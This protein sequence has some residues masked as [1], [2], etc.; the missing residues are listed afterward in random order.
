MDKERVDANGE[1]NMIQLLA[2]V[3]SPVGVAPG[4]RFRFEQWEPHLRAKHG[5]AFDYAPFESERLR[6]V[7]RLPGRELEKAAALVHDAVRRARVLGAAREYDGV[8]IHREISALGPAFYERIVK[9]LRVPIIFDFDDAIWL[10]AAYSDASVNSRFDALR[11]PQKTATICRLASAI[12]VGNEYLAEYAQQFNKNVFVVPT[13]IELAHYPIQSERPAG[14]AIEIVWMGSFSTLEAHLES[15]RTAIERFAKMRK[16]VVRVICDKPPKRP[17]TGT[18]T[19]FEEWRADR[20]AVAIGQGQIGIMPLPDDPFS[21]GKCGCKA[22][23]YMAA[24]RPAV[25]SPV[26]MNVDIARGGEAAILASSD[27]EWVEALDRL[28]SSADLRSRL[29]A[30]GRKVVE[31]QFSAEASAA[32]FAEVVRVA[33]GR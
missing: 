11:F 5:I 7:R 33:L 26:G 17:F 32:R 16:V 9:V 20:E 31:T 23:Q 15:A 24:G 19:I 22:L 1:R 10:R 25:L 14:D 4:Q 13:S 30:A 3:P 8:A 27:D 29:A 28:A 21:R 6:R 12:S 2:L 18:E